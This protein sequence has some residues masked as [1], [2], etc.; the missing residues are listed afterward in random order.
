MS[1]RR[2]A[3]FWSRWTMT[4]GQSCIGFASVLPWERAT[5]ARITS[6]RSIM[7]SLS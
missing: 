3:K 5:S 2:P 7:F 1:D 4:L 6:M